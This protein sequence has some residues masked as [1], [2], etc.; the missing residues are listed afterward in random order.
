M[1][2]DEDGLAQALQ[3][4]QQ[5]LVLAESGEV[6]ELAKLD[7]QRLRLLQSAAGRS[8]VPRSATEN[9]LLSEIAALNDRSLGLLEHRRR[10]KAREMD[11][12]TAGRKAVAAYSTTQRR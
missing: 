3:L 11:T 8:A 9:A 2:P 12:A 1:T 4:S 5:M 10:I 6:G 7:T